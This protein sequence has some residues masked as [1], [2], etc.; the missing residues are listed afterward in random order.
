MSS[1]S[2]PE[3]VITQIRRDL[4]NGE[5]VEDVAIRYG[6]SEDEVSQLLPRRRLNPKSEFESDLDKV[7]ATI[8]LVNAN[9]NANE[10][11]DRQIF[12]LTELMRTKN[13][14][15]ASILDAEDPKDVYREVHK[16]VLTPL[17]KETLKGLVVPAEKLRSQLDSLPSLRTAEK[18]YIKNLISQLIRDQSESL[19]SAYAGSRRDLANCLGLNP[20]EVLI[21]EKS[22]F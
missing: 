3:E 11:G 21:D 7:N 22:S 5:S 9:I 4:A 2:I 18:A 17:T 6:Y 13:D 10:G 1:G 15:V 8:E 12:A 20:E 16:A 14:L 19:K